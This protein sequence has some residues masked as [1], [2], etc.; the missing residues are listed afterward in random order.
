MWL[1]DF[2]PD[3]IPNARIMT[4]GYESDWRGADI[5]TSVRKCG[6]Q[7]LNV[8][9]QHR[10]SENVGRIVPDVHHLSLLSRYRR[11]EDRWC[12]LDIALGAWSLNRFV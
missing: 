6:E 11:A 10:S 8:L 9:L 1:R 7:L 4:Y 5:K 3:I 2:L 12:S